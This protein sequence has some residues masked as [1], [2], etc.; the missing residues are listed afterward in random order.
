MCSV[1]YQIQLLVLARCSGRVQVS[2][3]NN[4]I[5]EALCDESWGALDAVV[6]CRQLGCGSPLNTSSWTESGLRKDQISLSLS[7]SLGC[8]GQE[9]SLEECPTHNRTG[10]RNCSNTKGAVVTCSGD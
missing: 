1:D 7:L 6:A 10:V 2:N 3:N 8:S 4:N 5:S 9:G